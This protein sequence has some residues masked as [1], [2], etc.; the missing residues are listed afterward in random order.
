MPLEKII[1]QEE[2]DWYF[3]VIGMLQ[4]NYAFIYEEHNGRA[5]VYFLH[6]WG[7]TLNFLPNDETEFDSYEE[8]DLP[9]IVDS[10]EFP[11][12][13]DA[14]LA[15]KRNHFYLISKKGK[16]FDL[17]ARPIGKIF[18]DAR[19]YEPGIYSKQDEYWIK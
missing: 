2:P 11:D 15:L 12:L 7:S 14:Q 4:H 9:N 18:L 1:L 17:A 5:V 8:N 10:M 6:E 3:K 16:N 13:D 19:K